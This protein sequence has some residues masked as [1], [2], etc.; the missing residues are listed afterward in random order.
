ML[1]INNNS[2]NSAN[3]K[4][5]DKISNSSDNIKSGIL[6]KNKY[7]SVINNVISFVNT[8]NKL[9]NYVSTFLGTINPENLIYIL[10]KILN[11]YKT[12]KKLSNIISVNTWSSIKSTNLSSV[13]TDLNIKNILNSIKK[14]EVQFKNIHGISNLTT[15][16]SINM[17][18]VML[19]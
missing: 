16:L 9:P 7:L 15:L 14:K 19:I 5:V 3:L 1:N 13:I 18:I 10:S 12:N 11:F 4:N 2:N 8:N 17:K 6:I